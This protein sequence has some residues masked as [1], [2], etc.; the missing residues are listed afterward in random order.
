MTRLPI[1][2]RR[3]AVM[4]LTAAAFQ[5]PLLAQSGM[6]FNTAGRLDHKGGHHH[7]DGRAGPALHVNPRWK[8]CS[9]QLDA[10]L[11]QA[12]WRQFT[13]EAAVVTYFRPLTSAKPMGAGK[14]DVSLLQW[15]TA[16]DDSDAAWND[17]FVHPDSAHELLEGS[18]LQ[19]PGLSVRAGV[20]SRTDV[21]VYLTKNPQA[22]YGFYGAQVQ[23]N[24][25][26]DGW[27]KVSAAAR[28]SFVSMYGPEDVDFSVYGV[29]LLASREFTAWSG[30]AAVSPYAV[31][32][33]SLGRSRERSSVVDLEDENVLG[34]QGTV[35]VE[36]RLWRAKVAVEYGRARVSSF[37]VRVGVGSL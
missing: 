37:S 6:R 9:F 31:V 17:T 30:R 14:F 13:G 4:T 21:G 5:S 32:S 15:S 34:A 11:T 27:K 19:F 7:D 24:L 35:G 25:T 26:G 23:Q 18:S 20:T 3:A 33:T 22:N 36:A 16:I 2:I 1:A 28:V 8:E 29:D 10:A 12:A